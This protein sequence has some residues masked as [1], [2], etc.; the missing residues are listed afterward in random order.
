M[1]CL[2][3]QDVGVR[4]AAAS[5]LGQ[6]G[7]NSPAMVVPALLDALKKETNS[8]DALSLI[9]ALGRFGTNAQSAVTVLKNILELQPALPHLRQRR[10]AAMSAL[11][12][13]DPEAAKPFIEKWK[14]SLAGESPNALDLVRTPVPPAK[15][16]KN[17]MPSVQTN[18]ISP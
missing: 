8:L 10:W 14:A 5:A 12:R 17:S 3:D 13:I 1:L 4:G 11:K 16:L 2:S 6:I 9:G 7:T 18:S 15:Q